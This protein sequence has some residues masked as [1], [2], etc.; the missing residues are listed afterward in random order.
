MTT[1]FGPGNSINKKPSFA[2]KPSVTRAP[3]SMASA[4]AKAVYSKRGPMGPAEPASATAKTR[5]ALSEPNKKG[6]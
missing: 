4:R 1:A 3:S 5:T 6:Y 2:Q